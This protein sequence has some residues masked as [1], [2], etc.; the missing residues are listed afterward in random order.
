VTGAAQGIGLAVA[1]RIGGAGQPV[2]LV[3]RTEAKVRRAAEALDQCGTDVL[4]ITADVTD[5]TDV[6]RVVSSTLER[7]G[8][9]QALVNNAGIFKEQAF[10]DV[11]LTEWQRTIDINLTGSMLMAQAV[12][13]QMGANGRIVNVSS[14]SGAIAEPRFAAY[15]ASKTALVGLT[16]AMAVDLATRGITVNC[17][18]PGWVV[19]DMTV[20]YLSTWTREDFLQ[21]NLAGRAAEPREVAELVA[22]LC[23]AD[24]SFI[25][26]Q[27]VFIDGGQTIMATIPGQEVSG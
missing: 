9:I 7:F 3:G 4:A 17:V 1:Q 14:I 12:A 13:R 15:V 21:V 8:A 20:D 22:F 16:R 24:V 27:T 19:T 2:A 11:T 10:L 23:R 18:A 25:T 6:E 26:G 5:P